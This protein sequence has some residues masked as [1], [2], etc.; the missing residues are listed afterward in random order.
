[1]EPGLLVL[2]SDNLV[3]LLTP[4]PATSE[5]PPLVSPTDDFATFGSG[6]RSWRKFSLSF[7][8]VL[9][10]AL[11]CVQFAVTISNPG[12][13]DPDIWW[14]I[15]DAQY[16]LKNHHFLR[17]DIYSFT[18][19]GHPWVNTEWLSE[20]PFYFAYRTEGLAGLKAMT[21]ILPSILMLLLLYLCYRESRNFKASIV[22]CV[23]ATFLARVSYGPRTI[24]LGYMLL[25]LL[26]ILLRRFREQRGSPWLLPPLFCVWA[27]T[28]GSWSLG[29]ILF[30]FFGIAG[31]V[32]GCWG[33]VESVRWSAAQIRHLALAGAASVAALFVNPYG[34]RLVYYP[35]DLAFKQKLNVSHVAEWVPVNFQDL[36][37]KIVFALIAGLFAAAL[38][39]NRRW[40]LSDVLMLVFALYTALAHVRF[41][42]LLAIVVAPILAKLLD[43]FP[44]YRP[45]LDTPRV[46][47]A[48]MLAGVAA[49][50]WFWPHS[51]AIEKSLAE[52]YPTAAISYLKANPPQG[53]VLNFYLW[54]GYLG[55]SDPDMKVFIDS[56]VDIFEYEGVLQDYIDL[57]G[58]DTLVRR[59]DP[60]MQ[61]YKIRYVLFPP[62][63]TKNRLLGDSG[64]IY[65]LQHDPNWKVAY[66]DKICVLMEQTAD[67]P[68]AASGK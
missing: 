66:E 55:W 16:L 33:R 28:H 11:I 63:D 21:F 5:A 51:P 62:G 27:N 35:F 42:V 57:L 22:V 31:L 32:G 52:G 64:L 7:L 67:S 8:A 14:H 49:L 10:L 6:F 1:M 59:V 44:P 4:E 26:L 48:V 19:A 56:R 40:N 68:E 29:L 37:G 36:R 18:A 13:D 3:N 61:K 53:N 50:V 20:L 43:F 45:E 23:L 65:L 60:I 24:L 38:V 17:Q 30:F 58:S 25:V 15:R 41:L 9:T 47:V 54:G 12:F 39:R 46:N 34:W 2:H